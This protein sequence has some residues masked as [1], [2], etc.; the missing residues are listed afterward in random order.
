MGLLLVDVCLTVK[1]KLISSLLKFYVNSCLI[2][3]VSSIERKK[4]SWWGWGGA[5][6]KLL[7]AVQLFFAGPGLGMHPL[8][9]TTKLVGF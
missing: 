5:G 8:K 2:E 6:S 3:L 1:S 4:I 9:S 7:G